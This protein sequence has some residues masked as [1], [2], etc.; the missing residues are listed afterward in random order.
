MVGEHMQGTMRGSWRSRDAGSADKVTALHA[1]ASWLLVG[2]AS[3]AVQSY[4]LP[5]LRYTGA[6][7]WNLRL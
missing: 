2:R 4:E 5:S 6:E 1:S 3:G 7:V